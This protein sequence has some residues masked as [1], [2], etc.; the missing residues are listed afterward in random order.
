M[1]WLEYEY[2]VKCKKNSRMSKKSDIKFFIIIMGLL[3]L[4]LGPTLVMSEEKI[5]SSEIKNKRMLKML[6]PYNHISPRSPASFTPDDD[7]EVFPFEQTL[8]VDQIVIEDSAG[9]YNR[10]KNQIKNWIE[11]EDY[12]DSWNMKSTGLY[13]LPDDDKKKS[14][15]EKNAIKYFDRRLSGEIKRAEKGSTLA[16]VGRV[17]RALKPRTKVRITKNVKLRLKARLLQGVAY[18]FVDNPYIYSEA[19]INKYGELNM[20]LRKNLKDVG[21]SGEIKYEVHNS[22]WYAYV[23]KKITDKISARISSA[24]TDNSIL[25]SDKSDKVASISY[26]HYF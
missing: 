5:E 8:W 25:F 15:I 21:V 17:E 18:L 23:D 14:Y 6:N 7:V 2:S 10:V 1:E 9:V 16:K 4:A 13:P 26:S 19:V 22:M 11:V 24:Q 3:F 20:Y 12:V